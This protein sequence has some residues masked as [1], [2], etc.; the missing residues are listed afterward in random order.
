M[1]K[2]RFSETQI[3]AILREF[4]AGPPAEEL[5]RRHD[6]QAH[7]R[8]QSDDRRVA[9]INAGKEGGTSGGGGCGD[10]CCF[11]PGGAGGSARP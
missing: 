11:P 2:S 7:F 6:L 4:D 10:C 9:C 5:A 8:R 1:R 3:V